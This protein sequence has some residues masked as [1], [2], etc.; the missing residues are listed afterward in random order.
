MHISGPVEIKE[1]KTLVQ[2]GQA[3]PVSCFT[4]ECL[5]P[6]GRW[7]P[8][9]S[10]GSF[11]IADEDAEGSQGAWAALRLWRTKRKH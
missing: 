9:L 1:C 4:R 11:D 5:P 10:I 3:A 2:Q 6:F 7:K 8:W